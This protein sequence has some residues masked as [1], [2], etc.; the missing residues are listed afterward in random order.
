MELSMKKVLLSVLFFFILAPL[1]SIPPS[2]HAPPHEEWIEVGIGYQ[3][4]FPDLT[5]HITLNANIYKNSW[6]GGI[7]MAMGENSGTI[8]TFDVIYLWSPFD[9]VLLDIP[10]VLKAGLINEGLGFILQTG[11]KYFFYELSVEHRWYDQPFQLD[12]FSGELTGGLTMFLFGFYSQPPKFTPFAGLNFTYASQMGPG[13]G[14][15]Y[16]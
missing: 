4:S 13:S 2:L 5:H 14:Y 3:I 16:Y 12:Y 1:F 11:L 8:L 15:S 7:S 10:L 6:G 9:S